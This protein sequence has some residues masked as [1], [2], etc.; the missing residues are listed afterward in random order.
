MEAA[1]WQGT[2]WVKVTRLAKTKRAGISFGFRSAARKRGGLVYREQSRK[3][4][5]VRQRAGELLVRGAVCNEMEGRCGP[6]GARRHA[7]SAPRAVCLLC[8][9]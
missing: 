2:G 1:S 4:L 9:R 5:L 7:A 6:A 8:S 3:R